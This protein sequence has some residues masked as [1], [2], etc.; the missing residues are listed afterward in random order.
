MAIKINVERLLDNL[1]AG[2]IVH[3]IDTSVSYVN[4]E[5]L[6]ILNLTKDQILG[7]DI[8][9]S[10]WAFIDPSGKVL[11]PS[12]YPVS[13]AIRTKKSLNGMLIGVLD[14]E[15]RHPIWILM[16]LHFDKEQVVVS[17][18]DVSKEYELPFKEI[19]DNAYDGVLITSAHNLERP[20]GPK[21][22]YAN[23]YMQ[24]I[25]GY[26][27]DELI[28]NTPRILQGKDTDKKALYRIHNALKAKKVI[29]ETI[30]NY[31]KDNKPYWIDISIFP[32]HL[33]KD[34]KVTHFAAIERD[35]TDIKKN[36]LALVDV[37]RTDPLTQLLN[38][39][40]FDAHASVYTKKDSYA[41]VIL[42][43][44]HFKKIND[45]FSHLHGDKVLVSLAKIIK[46]HSRGDDL[47]VRF[48][49][50]EFIIFLP[51]TDK[52][53]AK[54]VAE[55]IRLEAQ[56]K[57]LIMN[58][59]DIRYTISCGIAANEGGLS[60]KQTLEAADKALYQ[61]KSQGRNRS[62]VFE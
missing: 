19:V 43:I 32:L 41:I 53:N 28:G 25:S 48:G 5:A 22:V 7:K 62:V 49:G 39:R 18:T 57:K 51:G 40:G 2:V 58:G 10:Q 29:R 9:G 13:I 37:S 31:S 38:R 36:E 16:N 4:K 20:Y 14:L 59:H 21:I 11:D 47:A 15:T 50:E 24:D 52:H 42:D 30:L 60:I 54:N 44:D 56:K 34:N 33:S 45:D 17:F 3:G 35:V 23:E 26:S 8:F 55:R 27:I 6:R 12:E 46:Q 1:P 61:A